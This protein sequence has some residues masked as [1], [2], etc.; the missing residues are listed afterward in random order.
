M[1]PFIQ[2]PTKDKIDP[3]DIPIFIEGY[4][5]VR[6]CYAYPEQYDVYAG[7]IQVAYLRLRSGRFTAVVPDVGGKIIYTAYPR[8][9]S[10]F[11]DDERLP[12]MKEAISKIQEWQLNLQLPVLD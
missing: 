6:T 9:D 3:L 1:T 5:I 7:D 4:K 12:Y 2:K 11:C 8:G 10:E